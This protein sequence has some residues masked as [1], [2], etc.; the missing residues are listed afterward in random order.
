MDQGIDLNYKLPPKLEKILEEFNWSIDTIGCSKSEVF[1]LTK[2][3]KA[4][5]LKVNKPDSSFNLENEKIILNWL[6][7]L[8]PVPEVI[9]FSK[10]EG[11]EFLLISEIDGRVSFEASS[12]EI[13]RKNIKILAEGLKRIHALDI[14]NCPLDNTPDNLIQIAQNKLKHKKIDSSKFD[15]RWKHKTPERLFEEILKIKP[16]KYDLVFSHGDYCLPNILVKEGKLN[17]IIDWSYGGINDRYFDF[18]AVA[19]SI[20]YNF[21][22]EWIQYF[23]EDYGLEDIDWDRLRFF[24]MLNEFFQISE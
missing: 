7:D 11:R 18:A 13:K 4:L 12:D 2:D 8:L 20:G 19:W 24:Q 5:Y 16:D 3:D 22:E 21:G 17:G 9:F 10:Y 14:S 1:K 6:K 23:F 15:D